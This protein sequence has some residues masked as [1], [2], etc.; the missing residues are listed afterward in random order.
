MKRNLVVLG[1]VLGSFVYSVPAAAQAKAGGAA[2]QS[3][4]IFRWKGKAPGLDL[5]NL[6]GSLQIVGVA[7]GTEMEIVGVATWQGSDAPQVKV[8]VKTSAEGVRVC[9]LYG[10]ATSCDEGHNSHNDRD[11]GWNNSSVA[12][13]VKLPR[14][15]R[16]EVDM[17]NGDV[18]AKGLA[19]DTDIETVNGRV[20][21]QQDTG[22]LEVETVNGEIALALGAVGNVD[23]ETV[24]GS[25]EI[26]LGKGQGGDVRAE[27]VNGSIAIAGERFKREGQKTVG[28]G[29]R[30]IDVETVNGSI[31]VQ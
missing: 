14:G 29:G 22:R 4:E 26:A 6:N 27:T 20:E 21:L 17:V 16:L 18:V 19:G 9:A 7:A 30:R 15:A 3:K 23:V 24:N 5:E 2:K 12:F 8:D 11:S 28:K 10:S 25:V 13:Q 31:S 1:L